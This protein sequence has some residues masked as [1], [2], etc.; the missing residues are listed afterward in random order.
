MINFF[1]K[2]FFI[3]FF[4]P[5]FLGGLSVFSFQ[6]FNFFFIN[7]FSLPALFWLILYVKKK[8]KSVYRK[9]P[10]V[11]NL[12][13]LG[14]SYGFGF[15]FFGLY[16]IIYSMTFD[17]AFKIFIPF[18]LFL[19]PLFLSLFFSLPIILSGYLINEKI[20][21]IF[22]V[23]FFFSFA[24]F[25]R[26]VVLTGFPWN[27]WI[28]SLS[29]NVENLQL[30]DSLGFFSLNLIIITLFFFPAILFFKNSSK[31][32]LLGT[33]VVLFFSNY[34]YGSYKINTESIGI[35]KENKKINFKI[36][37]A[38]FKLSEFK[39]PIDVA[40]RLIRISEPEKEKKTIFVWPEGTFMSE[41]FS[42]IKDNSAIRSLFKKN[43]S[44]NHLIIL[45]ANTAKKYNQEEKYFNSMVLVDSNFNIVAQ[46]DKK[47]LVPFGEFLPLENFLN[48]I[49]MKKITPGYS[50]FSNGTGESTLKFN[51][52]GNSLKLLPLIC[53]EIIFPNLIEDNTNQY[54]FIVN[55]SEDAWFGE[56]IGPYQHFAKAI[57]RS[58]ES[59]K[60][61]IRSANKGKSVFVDSNGKVIKS[62]EPIEAGN[63]E[64]ELPLLE[65]TKKQYKKSLIFY[66][67]LITYVFTFFVLR[68]F[69]I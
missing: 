60:F 66:S 34:F 39:D 21:S 62:L 61:V 69:K 65:S 43:F 9:N 15:F 49:G 37:T 23:S 59:R 41:N 27:L 20:S 8:S 64:L 44:K 26:S 46:Y 63:I 13:F 58:I 48:K 30:I 45:G 52:N 51:F 33:L 7:F 24:D 12:F 6:P 68:K 40:S 31:Y 36:V 35:N 3:L 32:F 18:G 50:S 55:I 57:F 1:N 42:N 17:D 67:L 4:F 22:L 28:Y 38:G 47:K 5:I 25:M 11:K 2:R 19:I 14:T 53:Y 56:S 54:N 10:F 29:N 16:W